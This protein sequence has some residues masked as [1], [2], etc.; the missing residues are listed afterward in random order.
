MRPIKL[1]LSAFGSY[2]GIN[3]IDFSVVDSEI[4]LI[5]GDTG[6]GKTTIFDAISYALYDIPS[7]ND[8]EASMLRS[9]LASPMDETY[10]DFTF[11]YRD[12]IYRIRRN[13]D[14]MRLS[15]KKSA[16]GSYKETKETA[17]VSLVYEDGSE[18]IGKKKE[19]NAE[20]VRILGLDA[21]QFKQV[22]M[23]A[24]GEFRKLLFASSEERK[25]IFAKIFATKTYEDITEK[26]KEQAKI[27]ADMLADVRTKIAYVIHGISKDDASEISNRLSE[28]Q[29]LQRIP[30]KEVLELLQLLYGIQREKEAEVVKEYEELHDALIR[31]EARYKSIVENNRRYDSQNHEVRSLESR[32]TKMVEDIGEYRTWIVQ[33]R[34][35]KEESLSTYQ[36][37]EEQYEKNISVFN[38]KLS[39]YMRYETV[40]T[41]Y[42]AAQQGYRSAISR[43]QKQKEIFD[44]VYQGF[45]RS[46]AGILADGL[47][48]NEPCPV[49]GSTHHPSKAVLQ[50]DSASKEEVE[51]A[52]RKFEEAEA[53]RQK[54]SDH[55]NEKKAVYEEVYQYLISQGE[56]IEDT[57]FDIRAKIEKVEYYIKALNNN[58]NL[59]RQQY[60]DLLSGISKMEGELKNLEKRLPEDENVL[61]ELKVQ[62]SQMERLDDSVLGIQSK[63]IKERL[64]ISDKRRMDIHKEISVLEDALQKLPKYFIKYKK[65]YDEYIVYERLSKI[66]SG[67]VSGSIKLDFETYVQ[68]FYFK[69][70][71][72]KA[73]QRLIKMSNHTFLLKT[74]DLKE[75]GLR[76]KEGL[77]LDIVDINTSSSR[78]VKS[79][80]GGEGFMASL[81]MALGLADMIGETCGAIRMETM[82]I[83]EGFGS[84]DD[85]TRTLAIE[86]LES[87]S[88]GK[89]LI[90]IISHVSELKEQIEAKLIVK[91]G[92]KGSWTYWE[93]V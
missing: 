45:I 37:Y 72:A 32:I 64:Q 38:Q 73:N 47:K 83:D 70:I 20:I 92:D 34:K 59:A 65:I 52:K 14:Y 90:G 4:F 84:L 9:K 93:G 17:S 43:V 76:S 29:A 16:D 18:Y 80:S 40:K 7:G 89:K 61:K 88:S 57:E 19:I 85:R 66:A 71:I 91:K 42:E 62:F 27:N 24:Q 36:R 23:L 10:V 87:L 49:C 69:Q 63:D 82:F 54:H 3:E 30:E 28:L 2:G 67:N 81:S 39:Y 50:E 11:E 77:N 5:T 78:D 13:P 35:K 15:R 22:S 46:Q 31:V 41:E 48:E 74:R 1:I 33:N 79:L 21:S 55:Y 53:G 44:A 26:L 68:R 75:A 86:T 6:A 8:R 58:R 60:E 25:V 51:N 12:K 56:R